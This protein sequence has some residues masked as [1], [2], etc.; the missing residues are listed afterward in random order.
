MIP[1]IK[2]NNKIKGYLINNTKHK[3][4]KVYFRVL[5]EDKTLKLVT[6][7]SNNYMF[8]YVPDIDCY[9][10][11]KDVIDKDMCEEYENTYTLQELIDRLYKKINYTVSWKS[12]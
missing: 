7:N 2:S 9:V 12:D 8:A 6:G 10:F 5:I 4:T 3:N 11:K 1:L